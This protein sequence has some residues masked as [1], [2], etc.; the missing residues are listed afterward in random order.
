MQKNRNRKLGNARGT[1]TAA[2]L[3]DQ[4][5]YR[6]KVALEEDNSQW[7]DTNKLLSPEEIIRLDAVLDRLDNNGMAGRK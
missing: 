1:D 6:C 3:L 2:A 4:K 7:T 5:T